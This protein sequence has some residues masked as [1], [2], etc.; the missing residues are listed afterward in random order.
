[1][2]ML[3]TIAITPV[4]IIY[5]AVT[6]MC[7]WNWFVI[8]FFKMAL[9]PLPVAIG[10]IALYGWTQPYQHRKGEEEAH[11]HMLYELIQ[12]GFLLLM[13]FIAKHWM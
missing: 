5:N 1:M 11:S 7:L 6:V 9:M 12:P 3:L 8:P 10:L 13:G 2:V 4:L